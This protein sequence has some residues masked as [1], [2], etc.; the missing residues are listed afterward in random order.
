MPRAAD[1]EPGAGSR[2]D[3]SGADDGDHTED[4]GLDHEVDDS[5]DDDDDTMPL[6]VRRPTARRR[7]ARRPPQAALD[8]G[9]DDDDDGRGDAGG[10]GEVQAEGRPQRVRFQETRFSDYRQETGE[11][12]KAVHPHANVATSTVALDHNLAGS[13][14]TPADGD[15]VLFLGCGQT[16]P[17][18]L[19]HQARD[20]SWG[21]VNVDLNYKLLNCQKYCL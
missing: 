15:Y 9:S 13:I 7:A 18:D 5:E 16:R 3:G 14:T 21:V 2:A 4:E 19:E 8:F 20:K 6:T 11:A 17:G 1:V 10:D 12:P